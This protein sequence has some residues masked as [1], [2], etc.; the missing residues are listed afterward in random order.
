MNKNENIAIS[1]KT[2][3][4]MQNVLMWERVAVTVSRGDKRVAFPDALK[5]FKPCGV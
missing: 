4:D 3:H 2:K 5:Q 1:N